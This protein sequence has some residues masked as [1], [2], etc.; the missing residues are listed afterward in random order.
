MRLQR[1]AKQLIEKPA[2][3]L[4]LPRSCTLPDLFDLILSERNLVTQTSIID[5]ILHSYRLFASADEVLQTIDTKFRVLC[6]S[7]SLDVDTKLDAIRLLRVFLSRWLQPPHVRDFDSA[8]G[9]SYLQRL[10]RMLADWFSVFRPKSS[11]CESGRT[12]ILV[13]GT[14]RSAAHPHLP[15]PDYPVIRCMFFNADPTRLERMAHKLDQLGNFAES[16]FRWAQMHQSRTIPTS[17]TRMNGGNLIGK[18]TVLFSNETSLRNIFCF[19]TSA[20]MYV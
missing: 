13:D 17:P 10:I 7:E 14:G 2:L 6:Y 5:A 3:T 15:C 16:R 4:S 1:Q 20:A 18:K 19:S 9:L 11:T 12:V 8:V